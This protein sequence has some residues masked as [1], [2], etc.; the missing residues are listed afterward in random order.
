MILKFKTDALE[1]QKKELSEKQKYLEVQQK[2]SHFASELHDGESCPL[3]GSLEHPNVVEFDDVN[4]E[5]NELQKQIENL[6]NQKQEIQKKSLEIEKILDRKNI[7]EEQLR[8]EEEI[9]KQIQIS[10]QN[11]TQN[12]IWKEFNAENEP[13][14]EQKR[15]QSFEIEKQIEDLVKQ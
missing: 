15:L 2:L 14:F 5:L 3:C 12:F 6:E 4:S 9:L 11:H 13:E 10:I 8:S 1:I 7:F